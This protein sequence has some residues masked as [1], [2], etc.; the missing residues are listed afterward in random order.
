LTRL[1]HEV[2]EHC[3]GSLVKRVTQSCRRGETVQWSPLF[4]W[5]AAMATRP[6]SWG[7]PSMRQL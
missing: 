5:A 6:S 2:V 4:D 1:V 7:T 3:L